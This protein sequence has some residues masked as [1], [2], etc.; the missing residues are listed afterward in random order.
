VARGAADLGLDVV[1]LDKL[2]SERILVGRRLP[3]H[4][5][6]LVFWSDVVGRIL[7]TFQAETHLK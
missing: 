6:Y 5:E 3:C 4:V 2:R 7:M 1:G